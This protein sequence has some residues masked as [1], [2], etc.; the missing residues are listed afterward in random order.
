M[1]QLIFLLTVLSFLSCNKQKDD[2]LQ[3]KDQA[4]TMADSL[5]AVADS[6]AMTRNLHSLQQGMHLHQNKDLAAVAHQ[7]PK[8]K[9]RFKRRQYEGM[10]AKKEAIRKRNEFIRKRMEEEKRK[11]EF[12]E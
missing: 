5:Q 9:V 2:T 8:K 6:L 10:A 11:R 1:K 7:D 3:Q 12:G 4:T